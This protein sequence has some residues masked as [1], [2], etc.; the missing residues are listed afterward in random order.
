MFWHNNTLVM[1][2]FICSRLH[3]HHIQRCGENLEFSIHFQRHPVCSSCTDLW[4]RPFRHLKLCPAQ[5]F[6]HCS[7]HHAASASHVSCRSD[8]NTTWQTTWLYITHFVLL[9]MWDLRRTIATQ[10]CW[11]PTIWCECFRPTVSTG[12]M[13]SHLLSWDID[14]MDMCSSSC[15]CRP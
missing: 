9:I 15:C 8:A 7:L 14:H 10:P 12:S 5:L 6:D 1:S 3:S 13:Q 4:F 11:L 2:C